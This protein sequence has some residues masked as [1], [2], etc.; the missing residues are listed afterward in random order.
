M[1]FKQTENNE[2]NYVKN[3]EESEL[4]TMVDCHS[5]TDAG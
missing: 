5:F 2:S 3:C 1:K 4:F